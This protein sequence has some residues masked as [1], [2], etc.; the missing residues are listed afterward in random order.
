M[1]EHPLARFPWRRGLAAGCCALI[2]IKAPA[3]CKTRLEQHLSVQRRIALA[4][5]MLALVIAAARE[6]H[7]VAQVFVLSPER[8]EVPEDVPVF[9]DSGLGLNQALTQAHRAL[10]A[11]GCREL[12]VLP[13]DLPTVSGAEIDR[14]VRAGRRGGFAIASDLAQ[15]GTNALCLATSQ[16]FQFRFGTGS[17]KLHLLE[18]RRLGLRAIT[19]SAPGL[20]F[21]IDTPADLQRWDDTACLTQRRA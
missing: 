3:Q 13:A 6:A 20:A 1:N 14:L 15:R 18:A 10:Q 5:R 16:P 7:N 8:D 21:D 4:R 12:V 9:A 2:A 17:R 19:V 11:I